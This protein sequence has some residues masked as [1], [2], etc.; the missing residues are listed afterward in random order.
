MD[1]RDRL[2]F[3]KYSLQV[4]FKNYN[5]LINSRQIKNLEKQ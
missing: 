5:N 2:S 4:R 1:Y 3:L